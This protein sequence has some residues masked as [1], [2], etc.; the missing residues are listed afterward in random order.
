LLPLILFTDEATFTHNGVS[1]ILASMVSRQSIWNCENAF[2]TSFLY[3][4]VV[5]CGTNEL[6]RQKSSCCGI[7]TEA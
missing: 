5:R 2:S 6:N 4:C 7:C 1:N 3:Q